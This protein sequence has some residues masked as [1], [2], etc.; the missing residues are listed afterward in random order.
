MVYDKYNLRFNKVYD[1]D[2]SIFHYY[3]KFLELFNN[4]IELIKKQI[5]TALDSIKPKTKNQIEKYFDLQ[6]K[7]LLNAIIV[8]VDDEN[9]FDNQV[10]RIKSKSKSKKLYFGLFKKE[11]FKLLDNMI[12]REVEYFI[13]TAEHKKY[14]YDPFKKNY[15]EFYCIYQTYVDLINEPS[16]KT[17]NKEF[18]TA[19][20]KNIPVRKFETA[21]SGVSFQ[22]QA[23][24]F[25]S[26]NKVL[27]KSI[28]EINIIIH[29]NL[30]ELE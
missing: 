13:N 16:K 5:D 29:N 6:Y 27:N 21:N 2:L 24:K 10:N 22:Q 7:V 15:D 19:F 25:V 20:R 4:E 17:R 28:D 1:K 8:L 23:R 11:I 18:I 3:L 12:F 30:K 26:A 9:D 14:I